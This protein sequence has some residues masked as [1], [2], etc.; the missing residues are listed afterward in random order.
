MDNFNIHKWKQNSKQSSKNNQEFDVYKWNV[1]RY[2][3]EGVND[4]EVDGK[5]S[6]LTYDFL[7][8]YFSDERFSAP[9]PDDS[10][11]Q[12]N[13]EGD[14]ESWKAK[15]MRSEEHTSELQSQD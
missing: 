7:S 15:T 9:N 13:D 2:L 10:S 12:I 5:L 3:N 1:N 11:R 14:W 4:R 6:D 8:G